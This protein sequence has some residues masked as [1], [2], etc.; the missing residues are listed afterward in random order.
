MRNPNRGNSPYRVVL[1]LSRVQKSRLDH[2]AHIDGSRPA[3][4]AKSIVNRATRDTLAQEIA[5][6]LL[7]G[8]EGKR[9]QLALLLT[10]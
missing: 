5:K 3:S 2:C 6:P 7:P 10:E 4:L 9:D 1:N 8:F